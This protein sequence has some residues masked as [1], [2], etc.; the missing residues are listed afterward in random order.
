MTARAQTREVDHFKSLGAIGVIPKPF[1]PMTLAGSVRDFVR[2]MEDPLDDLRADFLLRVKRDAATL[3]EDRQSLRAGN[4]ALDTIDRIKH[5]AHGLSG[6]GGLYGFVDIS[7]AATVLEDAAIAELSG[8]S[9]AY[10][11]DHA[12]DCLI[13]QTGKCRDGG[14]RP[15]A[16]SG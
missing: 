12:L 8:S 7:D 14:G 4:R 13:F 11:T 2:P 6:A 10:E 1:D 15:D 9:T 5:I 16:A 3:S